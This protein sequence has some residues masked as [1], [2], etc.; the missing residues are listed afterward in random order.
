MFLDVGVPLLLGPFKFLRLDFYAFVKPYGLP[1][2]DHL[3]MRTSMTFPA[4]GAVPTD[5]DCQLVDTKMRKDDP[6]LPL[7]RGVTRGRGCG[8][9]GGTEAGGL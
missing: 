3:M 4:H 5:M 9:R 1:L 6:F 7:G 2:F 8:S